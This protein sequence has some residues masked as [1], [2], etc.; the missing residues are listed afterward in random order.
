MYKMSNYKSSRLNLYDS[1]NFVQVFEIKNEVDKVS[2]NSV[3]E[4]EFNATAIKFV[5]KDSNGDVVDQVADVVQQINEN[6]DNILNETADRTSADS[7][8]EQKISDEAT[9]RQSGDLVLDGKIDS[10]IV[11]RTSAD[12]ALDGKISDEATARTAA[13]SQLQSSI[14]TEKAR[15]DAILAGS[16]VNLDTF[17]EVVTYVNS[18]DSTQLNLLQNQQSQI[19]TLQNQ[20]NDLQAIIDNF[21]PLSGRGN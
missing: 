13:D 21:V 20:V 16:D 4:S 9:A 17:T 7:A 18:L 6:K 5:K 14:D 8:L 15:I 1:T 11:N 10:E 19:T 3:G 12:S 2:Y